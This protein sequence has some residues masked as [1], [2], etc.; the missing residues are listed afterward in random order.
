MVTSFDNT[1]ERKTTKSDDKNDDNDRMGAIDQFFFL[2]DLSLLFF[3][4]K[5]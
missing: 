1:L 4:Q 3:L 5:F 2:M